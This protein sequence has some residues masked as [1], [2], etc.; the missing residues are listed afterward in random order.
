MG[1][2]MKTKWDRDFGFDVGESEGHRVDVHWG[3]WGGLAEVCV[4]GRTVLRDRQ[5][6]SLR[7]TR[8]YRFDVG[9][10]EVHSVTV[11][12]RRRPVL[13]GLQ[14]Q[15]FRALVDSRLVGEF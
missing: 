12:K 11:E 15:T 10:S 4:D 14:K 1:I 5:H 6:F 2:L 7:R 3:Q 9:E 13:G 8:R